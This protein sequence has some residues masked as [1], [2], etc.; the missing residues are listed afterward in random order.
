MKKLF[1][2]IA[3]SFSAICF[4]QSFS[5]YKTNASFVPT[6][7]LSNGGFIYESTSPNVLEITKMLIKNNATITQTFNV[8]R[9]IISQSPML[10]QTIAANAPTTYFCFGFNCFTPPVSTPSSADYT[11]L[12]ASGQTSTTFPFADNTKDNGQPFSIDLEEGPSTGSYVVKYKVFNVANA[13]DTLAF[14]LGY[15]QPLGLR[16]NN[17]TSSFSLNV[18]P[19]PAID[20]VNV[21]VN[22]NDVNDITLKI[23]N[24][25][26][27]VVYS[28]L[29]KLTT[30]T[31]TINFESK[32]LS[33]GIYNVIVESNEIKKST[34]LIITK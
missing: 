27:Q 23:M 15:N 8:T 17:E 18:F 31:N 12:L 1:T 20:N 19:N 26:G 21:T 14:F 28:N 6:A 29:Y 25:M 22:S 16:H 9:T 10:D 4:A 24:V 30:G 3:V 13:N 7:T 11:I 33:S 32:N 34:K 5:V 2:L